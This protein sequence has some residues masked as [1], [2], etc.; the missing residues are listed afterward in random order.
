MDSSVHAL[1]VDGLGNLYAGGEFTNAGGVPANRVAMWDGSAWSALGSGMDGWY[2]GALVVD[3]QGNL[4]A[5]G[6]FTIAGGAPANR[7][8][9]WDGSTW[10]PLGNGMDDQV[11]ALAIDAD[12]YLYA[13]GWFTSAGGVPANG[14][15]RW[16]GSAWEALGTGATAVDSLA[17]DPN[18]ILYATGMFFIPPDSDI[19]THYIAQLDGSSWSALGKGV[20][21]FVHALA[22][23]SRGNLYAA[24]NFGEAGGAPA[25]RIARWDGTSWNALGSGIGTAG[26]YS[27]VASLAVAPNDDVFVGGSFM[28]AGLKP[29]ANIA[30]WD[31][32]LETTGPIAKVTVTETRPLSTP[33][34]TQQI[35]QLAKALETSTNTPAL[36]PVATATTA[37]TAVAQPE[38]RVLL[39]GIA[40]LAI[41]LILL[42]VYLR[43]RSRLW[44]AKD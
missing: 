29:S 23:D 15:A 1:A 32:G 9:M 34:A 4:Y 24:G 28:I 40:S 25:T 38:G 42:I 19:F 26:D 36:L 27:S 10:S 2:V 7:I 20:N 8:A 35:N 33:T 43:Y 30:R 3:R 17:I 37:S 31:S 22:V 39:I 13:G 41:P 6:D 21:D 11:N 16:N 5:G 44:K 12:G 18:G 14:I